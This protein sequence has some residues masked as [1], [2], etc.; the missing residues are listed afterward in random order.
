MKSVSN[1]RIQLTLNVC[2]LYYEGNLS[3]NEIAKKLSISRPTVSRLLQ[4][5][6]EQG[7]VKIEIIDPL[8][9]L[10]MLATQLEQKYQLKKVLIAY[11]TTNDTTLIN[12]KLGELAAQFLDEIVEDHDRIGISWGQT[13]EAVASHLKPS[14]R[15]DVSVIQLKGSVP[16]SDM[17]NFAN[18]IN[19]KFG[20]AFQTNT[21]NLPLPVIFDNA[22]TKEIVSKDRFIQALIEAGLRTNIALFT[23]GTVRS[24][25]M[26]FNL[27][28]LS[29]AEIER[30][31][32]NS[33]GDIISRFI[34][35]DGQIA[36]PDIDARTVAI[37]LEALKHKKYSMLI[38]GSS[39][40]VASIH[41][42]LSGGY[43]NV[44]ITDSQAAAALLKI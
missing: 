42:A 35:P 6:L 13:I 37:S 17:N 19:Q 21:L 34:T 26:L 32:K 10:T 4:S 38:A 39:K 16:A 5:A 23:S 11:D 24:N 28:Y 43:A 1:D 22:V 36:D 33:V 29:P 7:L 8:E 40:K 3:Q 25:A 27:G 30:V 41:A 15:R 18:D 9:N 2:H 44:L 20:N 31:Q 12:D 14:E